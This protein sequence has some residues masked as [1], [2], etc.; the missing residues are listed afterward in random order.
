[1]KR[2]QERKQMTS[3]ILPPILE[4]Q[5]QGHVI[6]TLDLISSQT[7]CHH[8]FFHLIKLF[9]LKFWFLGLLFCLQNFA[10]QV[11][12]E[13]CLLAFE[14]CIMP[15]LTWPHLTLLPY[16]SP[17]FHQPELLSNAIKVMWFIMDYKLPGSRDLVFIHLVSP[18]CFPGC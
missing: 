12:N 5:L 8:F 15:Q 18:Q 7:P 13:L 11:R 17:F 2:P 4:N 14:I 3:S 16:L 10:Y 1:M 9:K 6:L